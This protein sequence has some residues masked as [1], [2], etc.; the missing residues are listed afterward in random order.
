MKRLTVVVFILSTLSLFCKKNIWGEVPLDIFLLAAGL[1]SNTSASPAPEP[2]PTWPVIQKDYDGTIFALAVHE[3]YIFAAGQEGDARRWRLEKIH[4][5]TGRLDERFGTLGI[6]IH[7]PDST[8]PSG[9]IT[10]LFVDGN[11]L[12][13]AGFESTGILLL[14]KRWRIEKRDAITGDPD[15]NFGLA[16]VIV[17]DPSSDWEKLTDIHIS[18][19]YM[20]AVG[21]S[22]GEWRL[23]KRDK[24]TGRL[25]KSFGTNGI[26]SVNIDS[27]QDIA[28]SISSDASHLYIAGIWENPFRITNTDSWR[29]EKRD[30]LTGALDAG[31]GNGGVKDLPWGSLNQI[32]VHNGFIYAVG[33][34]G[35]A[36]TYDY[37]WRLEK[38]NASDGTP[39]SGFGTNGVIIYNA[40]SYPENIFS[41]AFSQ[42]AIYLSG[43]TSE[44]YNIWRIEKR[45]ATTGA[46]NENFG[47]GGAAIP[48]PSDS[49]YNGIPYA[50]TLD[51]G[52]LYVGGVYKERWRIDKLDLTTGAAPTN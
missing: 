4:K 45:D 33:N 14:D 28:N 5:I 20:Y 27:G 39:V 40:D 35:N 51:A 38:I 47:T 46:L 44:N 26:I 2:A 18:G 34:E 29:I 8:Y 31:F 50:M 7:T 30:I 11:S 17:S 41:I 16:G 48:F 42:G 43:F 19:N 15:A 37:H 12:Y 22:R 10:S 1:N 9:K 49:I 6:L 24:F 52:H 13:I 23:E 36:E 25:V 3:D 32:I 21:E